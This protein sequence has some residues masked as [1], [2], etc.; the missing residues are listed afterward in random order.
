VSTDP[1]ACIVMTTVETSEAAASLSQRLVK[2]RLAACV[3]RLAVESCYEWEGALEDTTETLLLV[4]TTMARYPDDAAWLA[5]NHPYDVPEVVMV[6][7]GAV[8][9]DYL[10]WVARMTTFRPG[11]SPQP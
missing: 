2:E 1:E 10:A 5:E 6:P 3:Q 7:A 8:S 4:K 11:A 9:T